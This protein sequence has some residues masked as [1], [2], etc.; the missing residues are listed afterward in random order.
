MKKSEGAD[1]KRT[2]LALIPFLLIILLA[3]EFAGFNI[4]LFGNGGGGGDSGGSSGSSGAA[5]EAGV[6]SPGNNATVPMGPVEVAYHASSAD[7][8][9]M[10]ELSIDGA[11]VSSIPAPTSN[12]KV[13]A[14]K[15]AWTPANAGS[16]TIRVRAQSNGGDWSDYY[17]VMVTVQAS[18]PA[19][20]A[21]QPPAQVQPQ[22]PQPQPQAPTN[23][24]EPTPT[25]KD[26]QVYD[27]KF[28]KEIFYYGGG[29]CNREITVSAKV[30]QPEKAYAV[31]LFTRFWDKEGGGLSKWDSGR[32][33]SRKS[34]G[35][36]SVTL[37]S[38]KIPNYNQFEF[39]IMYVQIKVQDKS[40]NILAG[41][42][43]IKE[44]TLQ[45]CQ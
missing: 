39:S 14:L 7:G 36:Y 5:V 17:G 37:F 41:T 4:D 42:D 2:Y 1:M 31:I 32:A 27:V 6:D 18:Q 26:M 16:H 34:E 9:A 38:E 33:M 40:G 22:Q 30:T 11:V 8:I 19:P 44:V 12:E 21:Q 10:V 3:C 43:V 28:D 23:T 29:G 35:E 15:Y 20:Q 24:P 13:M 25:P 45:V